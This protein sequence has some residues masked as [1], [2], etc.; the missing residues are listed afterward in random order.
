MNNSTYYSW[1]TVPPADARKDPDKEF[2]FATRAARHK[3]TREND[4]ADSEFYKALINTAPRDLQAIS[5]AQTTF[6]Q[7]LATASEDY[8]QAL[9]NAERARLYATSLSKAPI[10]S[11]VSSPPTLD[12]LSDLVKRLAMQH[13]AELASRLFP[14]RCTVTNAA[15][16]SGQSSLNG[17]HRSRNGSFAP[18]WHQGLG[19]QSLRK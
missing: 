19:F 14:V 15:I 7:A 4:S 2:E 16:G 8:H 18:L 5:N 3:L 10:D 11:R 1:S 13:A 9:A 12:P 17:D 6:A